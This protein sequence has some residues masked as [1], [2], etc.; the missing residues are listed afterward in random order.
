M[1]N[2]IIKICNMCHQQFILEELVSNPE[3]ELIGMSFNENV[4]TAYYFFQHNVPHCGT[5]FIVDANE[6]KD[7]IPE[8]IPE[9]NLS[10]T[11]NCRQ[12]CTNLEDLET[13]DREC[14]QAPFRRFLVH[15]I[16]QKSKVKAA[17]HLKVKI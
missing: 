9:D 6:F 15:L 3:L 17:R 8:K 2:K 13:C 1:A 7:L 5:S 14:Y 11:D 10:L 16:E 12:H 4:R